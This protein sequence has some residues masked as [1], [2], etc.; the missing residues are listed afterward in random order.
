MGVRVFYTQAETD[1]IMEMYPD[2]YTQDIAD[3]IGKD[4]KSIYKMP[5]N[6]NF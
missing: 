3:K 4:L 2:H 1:I 6:V 5:Q